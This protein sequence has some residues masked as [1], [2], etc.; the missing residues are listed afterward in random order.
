M[1]RAAVR[2]GLAAARAAGLR[3]YAVA[4]LS[5]LPAV[6]ADLT[7]NILLVLAGLIVQVVVSFAL[8]RVLGAFR[9]VPVPA[10]PQVDDQ[11]R[12]VL[13]PREPGPPLTAGDRR[14]RVA[15][16]NA[17]ALWRPGLSFTG[18][19]LLAQVGAL[20]A[21]LALSGGKATDYSSNVLLLSAVPV[22]ALFMAFLLLAPQRIA[23]EGETRVVVAVAHS[24]R[25]ARTTYPLLLLLTVLEPLLMALAA[26][27]VPDKDPSLAL[28]AGV[29]GGAA[30]L[31]SVL[32]VLTTA[33]A[34]EVY[35]A[36]PRLELPAEAG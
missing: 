36:G 34:N 18:L 27:L 7:G 35:L 14:V 20:L 2:D 30:L 26:L 17:F 28:A 23:L 5:Y 1:L 13:P 11:G 4:V 15:L 22:S 31:A 25:I 21:V 24:V 3:A 8:I 12:R 29:G 33:V 16:R 9:P 19:V 32:Q 10:P 6:G